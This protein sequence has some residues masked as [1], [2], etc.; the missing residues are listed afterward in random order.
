MMSRGTPV[1]E[2]EEISENHHGSGGLEFI[3]SQLAPMANGPKPRPGWW[4]LAL[5]MTVGGV[6]L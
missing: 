2:A 3:D 6:R 1:G 5:E 4:L